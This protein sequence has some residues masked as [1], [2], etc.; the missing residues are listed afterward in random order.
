MT[1]SASC[2]VAFS[3]KN[4]LTSQVCSSP[5]SPQLD[6]RLTMNWKILSLRGSW[7]DIGAVPYLPRANED[8]LERNR[9]LG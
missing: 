4:R 7:P 8:A 5:V 2:H 9:Q 3:C 6:D 1:C